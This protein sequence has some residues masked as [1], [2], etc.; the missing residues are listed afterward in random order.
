MGNRIHLTTDDIG[1]SVAENKWQ[2]TA[3]ILG[4]CE[5]NGATKALSLGAGI[6]IRFD[7]SSDDE[8]LFNVALFRN[9]LVYDG[10]NINVEID[11]MKY[12]S[13]GGTVLWELDY[14]FVSIGENAYSKQ[15]GTI[16]KTVDVSAL[17]NQVLTTTSLGAI[18]GV[19]GAKILILTLRRNST[20]VGSD[21][22]SGDAEV[23]GFNI[24]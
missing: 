12:G 22:Y 8:I 18:S 3:I 6:Y 13:T 9:G 4:S 20:G 16:T 2:P 5:V 24:Y 14:A 15:D 7:P 19:A 1:V 21:T 11:W 23:Y 10:S 17:G